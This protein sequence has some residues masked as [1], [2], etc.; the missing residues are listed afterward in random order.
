MFESRQKKILKTIKKYFFMIHPSGLDEGC[1]TATHLA[2]IRHW[3][4]VN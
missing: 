3:A 1:S 2:S 4:Y